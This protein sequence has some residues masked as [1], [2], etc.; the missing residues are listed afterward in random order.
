MLRLSELCEYC[1]IICE[2]LFFDMEKFID[3]RGDLFN[4]QHFASN[5]VLLVEF[6]SELGQLSHDLEKLRLGL[7]MLEGQSL[8]LQSLL[9]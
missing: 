4:F 7:G 3:L 2:H 6:I 9:F 1:L 8:Q 5:R